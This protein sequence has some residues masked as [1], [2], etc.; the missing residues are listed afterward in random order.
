MAKR[1][2]QRTHISVRKKREEEARRSKRRAFWEKRRKT[3]L[4]AAVILAAVIAGAWTAI[5]YFDTPGGSMRYFAGKLVDKQPDQIIQNLGTT[6]SPRYYC[7]GAMQSPEGY[8]L[9]PDSYAAS[10][11]KGEEQ[12]FFFNADDENALIQEVYVT[13][14]DGKTSLQMVEDVA[15]NTMLAK[16]IVAR[17]SAEIE[18]HTV[19]FLCYCM[20]SSTKDGWLTT[21]VMYED[22]IRDGCVLVSC[23]S[24]KLPK[25]QLPTA[26]QMLAAAQPMLAC[27][28]VNK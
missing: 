5:D 9:D 21:L 1:H 3:I 7:Y 28:T 12:N 18:G 27:L 23:T 2:Q 25:D 4:I 8:T 11:T 13:G 6:K 24:G 19:N 26:E 15:G 10:S 14:I 16:E 20:E 22:S 17:D